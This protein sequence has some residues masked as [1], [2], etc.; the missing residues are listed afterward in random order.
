M[1]RAAFAPAA[2]L[3]CSLFVVS[4][5]FAQAKP[6]Q[7]PATNAAAS[8]T[9]Q[10]PAAPVKYFK[11][12]KGTATIEFIPGT[13]RKIGSDIVTVMKVKNKS[14]GAIHLLKIDEY[15]YNKERQVVTGDTQRYLKPLNPGEI[16]EITLSTPFKPNLYVA[17]WQ[18]SHANGDVKVNKVK[19]FE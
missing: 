18:F 15:W 6:A 12:V 9:A 17:Q 2:T 11:P 4:A 14:V 16:A 13:P 10:A 1:T 5:A 3:L 19:K 8:T 7:A